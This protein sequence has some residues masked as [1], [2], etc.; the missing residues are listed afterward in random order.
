M[1][2]QFFSQE[3][4][5]TLKSK[6]KVRQWLINILAEEKH[7]VGDISIIF[8]SDSYL[9]SINNQYLKHNYYTDI[10]SFLYNKEGQTISGD[11]FISIDRVKENAK[12]YKVK[13][14]NELCRVMAHGVLHLLGY[15]DNSETEKVLIRAKENYFLLKYDE[16]D[17]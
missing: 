7:A 16:S 12:D 10:I 5:F 1:P 14:V 6:K 3:I 13:F 9:L 4:L 17:N 2:I 8:C 11:L 15:G